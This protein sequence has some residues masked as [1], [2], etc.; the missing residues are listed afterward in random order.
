MSIFTPTVHTHN[1]NI[2]DSETSSDK[3]SSNYD[4]SE[5]DS[6]YPDDLPKLDSIVMTVL[7]KFITRAEFG[8]KKYG[9]DLDREDLTMLEWINHAQEEHMDAIL[10]LEKIRN[11]ETRRLTENPQKKD[12]Q[13]KTDT[14]KIMTQCVAV[15]IAI[16]CYECTI[17]YFWSGR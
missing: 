10:Y 13:L 15:F 6:D 9:T 8:K 11:L 7:D 17:V 5:Y 14:L 2:Y 4:D 1:L 3:D 16:V 12:T